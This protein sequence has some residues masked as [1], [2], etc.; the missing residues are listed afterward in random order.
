MKPLPLTTF[1][2]YLLWEDRPAYPWS[3]FI[4]L[5][6]QGVLD[7]PSL[8]AAIARIRDRHPLLSSTVDRV[9]RR[10]HW[11]PTTASPRIDWHNSHEA[12]SPLFPPATYLDITRESGLRFQV[13]AG[14]S[15]SRLVVQF[16]HACCDGA[17]IMYYLQDLFVAYALERGETAPRVRLPELDAD[18]LHQRGQYGLTWSK[19]FQLLPRQLIGLQGARQFIQ[20]RPTPVVPHQVVPNDDQPPVNYPAAAHYRFTADETQALRQRAQANDVT[21]NDLFARNLFGALIEWRRRHAAPSATDQD[22]LRMMI[23]M[24]L[25]NPGDRELSAANVVSSVFLDRRG[26]DLADPDQLLRSIHEEMDLIKSNQLGLT[27][28]FSLAVCRRLPGGLRQTARKDQCTVSCIFTN[29][30]KIFVRTPVPRSHG[31]LVVGDLVLESC[32]IIAPLRPHNCVTFAAHQYAGRL[33]MTLH[34]DPRVLA[35]SQAQELLDT[36]VRRSREE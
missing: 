26:L 4:D 2:E 25:R 3:C 24:N 15:S 27:F 23:P 21:T 5:Q 30:G 12:G 31:R 33:A 18:R 13:F 20:R 35:A 7:R 36:F 6:F 9:G 19:F 10:P 8:E 32:Q 11:V 1:E 28:L 29:L 34:Y 22:W 17:G 14:E 16:H